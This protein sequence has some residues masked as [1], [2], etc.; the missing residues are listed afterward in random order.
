MSVKQWWNTQHHAAREACTLSIIACFALCSLWLIPDSDQELNSHTPLFNQASS[1]RVQSPHGSYSLVF[2]EQLGFIGDQSFQP[3]ARIKR[4]ETINLRKSL[5]QTSIMRS[6][7]QAQ[8]DQEQQ[9]AYGFDKGVSI[10]APGH[11]AWTLASGLDGRAY[12]LDADGGLYELNVDLAS[13]V[14]RPV[15]ALRDSSLGLPEQLERVTN[16]YSTPNW[17]LQYMHTHWWL[18]QKSGNPVLIDQ[19]ICNDWINVFTHIQAVTFL[20]APKAAQQTK[21]IEF[22]GT[23]NQTGRSVIQI[24]DNG[25]ARNS[26]TLRIIE[27]REKIAGFTLREFFAADIDHYLFTYPNTAFRSKQLI[28]FNPQNSSHIRVGSFSIKKIGNK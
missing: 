7:G 18:Q 20:N 10:N 27:R 15:E 8:L 6:L 25:P 13:L 5:K 28:P 19:R 3:I 9:I 16:Y 17:S 24:F 22:E 12:A 26:E 23:N 2:S 14:N 11:D 21:M 4:S 1:F